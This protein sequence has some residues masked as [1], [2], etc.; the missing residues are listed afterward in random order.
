M[1]GRLQLGIGHRH[2]LAQHFGAAA[3]GG[4]VQGEQWRTGVYRLVGAHL[5]LLDHA[6]DGGTD[7]LRLARYDLR[8]GQCGLPYR[9]QQQ[10]PEY[11]QA[12]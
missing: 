10:G 3:Q 5:D 7:D 1:A 2:F 11:D 12:Q 9:Q 6:I 4:F 8:R